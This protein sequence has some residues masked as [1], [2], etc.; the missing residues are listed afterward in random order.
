MLRFLRRRRRLQFVVVWWPDY[1]N[2]PIPDM[3][4]LIGPFRSQMKALEVRNRIRGQQHRS[5]KTAHVTFI[6]PAS[7]A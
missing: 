3:P 1:G 7:R 5:E 4:E 6:E 2:L